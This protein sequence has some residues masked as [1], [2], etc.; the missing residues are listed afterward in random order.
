MM[1]L[2]TG[3]GRGVSLMSNKA[4]LACRNATTKLQSLSEICS[5]ADLLPQGVG[6]CEGLPAFIPPARVN[7]GCKNC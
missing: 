5:E 4:N 7:R 6:E 1:Q 2:I 3:A